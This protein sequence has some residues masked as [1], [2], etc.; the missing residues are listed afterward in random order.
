MKKYFTLNRETS[1]LDVLNS[2]KPNIYTLLDSEDGNFIFAWDNETVLIQIDY[3][4]DKLKSFENKNKGKYI[5]G[6]IGYDAKK[7]YINSSI[8]ENTNFDNF[9]ESI[10]YI[11]LHVLIKKND[12]YIYYGTEENFNIINKIPKSRNQ[13]IINNKITVNLKSNTEKKEYLKNVKSIKN[14]IQNGDIYE[15]NYCINFSNNNCKL[16]V[17]NTFLKL[18]K[19]T[20]APFSTLF[21]FEDFHILSASPERFFNKKKNSIISQPIKGTA[22]RGAS[23]MEDKKNKLSLKNDIKELAENI[24][25]VD[26]V[27]NDFSRFSNKNSVIVTELCKLYSFKNIHQLISTINSRIDQNTTFEEIVSYIFPMGS[28]TG[29]PKNNAIK[30]IEQFEQF[31]RNVYSGSIGHISPN[32]N[33]DFNVIIRSIL[34]NLKRK[35]ISIGVGGAITHKSIPSKEYSECL[36]KLNSVKHSIIIE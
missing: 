3:N 35:T 34:H 31:K 17:L 21:K 11:P 36:L 28:M 29:A 7:S 23:I 32:N 16:D 22:A 27:R 13:Q 9:P 18:K 1:W 33:M 24:M 25:I 4:S 14:L 2:L 26:L 6:Y 8:S 15:L 12:H 30:Y 19:N 20:K 10:F 5:F